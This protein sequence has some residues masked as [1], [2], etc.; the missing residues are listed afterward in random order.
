MEYEVHEY[1]DVVVF[2]LAGCLRGNPG[3]YRFLERVRRELK[4][5]KRKKLIV[6]L[7]GLEKMDSAGVG[8]L[9]SVFTA[10]ENA[11]ASLVFVNIPGRLK[12]TLAVVRLMRLLNVMPSVDEALGRMAVQALP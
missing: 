8:I 6:D 4:R 10:A 3:S 1:H 5:L 9:A 7:G 12:K 2:K 11:G